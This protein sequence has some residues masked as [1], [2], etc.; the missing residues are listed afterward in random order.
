MISRP[1]D[2]E[3]AR[4]TA[5]ESV[6]GLV[7]LIAGVL[8]TRLGGVADVVGLA[9]ALL[10]VGGLGHAVLYGLGLANLPQ[11][12]EHGAKRTKNQGGHRDDAHD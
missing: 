2:P 9:M 5:W 10:G 11:T 7:M 12:E 3:R 6:C 1:E 8:L 4:V